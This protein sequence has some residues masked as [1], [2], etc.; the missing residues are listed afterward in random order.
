MVFSQSLKKIKLQSPV[1][2]SVRMDLLNSTLRSGVTTKLDWSGTDVS[3]N[4][5]KLVNVV[6]PTAT[7]DAATKNYVDTRTLNDLADTI[8]STPTTNQLLQYNGTNWVNQTVSLSP[9][10]GS[11]TGTLSSQTDLQTALNSKTNT[12]LN[13]VTGSGIIS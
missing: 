2:S 6:D 9:T 12:S 11:I 10:W 4:T 7:Q 13:N 8:I 5:R 1:G 3:L